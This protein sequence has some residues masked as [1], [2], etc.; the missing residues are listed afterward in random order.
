[1]G[2]QIKQESNQ[3]MSNAYSVT[4]SRILGTDFLFKTLYSTF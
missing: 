4:S 1:M 2:Y 3:D